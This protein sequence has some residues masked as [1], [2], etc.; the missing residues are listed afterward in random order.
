MTTFIAFLLHAYQPPTQDV[1]ILKKINQESYIPILKLMEEF[2]FSRF[3][4]N[5]NGVLIDLL[6]EHGLLEPIELL[7]KLLISNKIE[8]LGTAKYHPILPLIPEREVLRQ[9]HLNE[10]LNEKVFGKYWKKRGFFPPEMA[11]SP[12]LLK[13][14]Q[15]LNY[16]WI[17]CS[18]IAFPM[19]ENKSKLKWPKDYICLYDNDF[20]VLFRDDILSN[21]IAFNHVSAKDF[22]E[23]LVNS[24][25]HDNYSIIAVDMET[26]G[27]HI[28]NYEKLFLKTL[29]ELISENK[30]IQLVTISELIQ[31]F[32]KNPQENIVPRESSW[33]T[34][35]EDL[36][37]KI[38][39]PLWNHPDNKIHYFYWKAM[40]S[41]NNLMFLADKSCSNP[42]ENEMKNY[43]ITARY[44][45]DRSL[46]S[47]PMWWANPLH[48]LF[49]PNLIYKGLDLMMKAALNAQL[50]LEYGGIQSGEGYFDS[51]TYYQGLILMEL[52]AVVR[53]I[54]KK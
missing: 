31:L 1:E 42:S 37:K 43:Y 4:L 38:P 48:G 47:C 17:I 15:K 51:I 30:S 21:R 11:I 12:S 39:F 5:V 18:G 53:R 2:D 41:L 44:F 13:I 19:D 10:Q 34:T 23:E 32:K 16:K 24:N 50:A 8:L 25:L 35:Q 7:K 46:H 40:R 3:N 52:Y 14:I 22:Y 9:I 45:H 28:K 54:V 6:E 29:L 33:S 26:F 20:H 49:S 36:K 27:H